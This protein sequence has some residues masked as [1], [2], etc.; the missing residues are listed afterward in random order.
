MNSH[1]KANKAS[2]K[3]L[4]ESR[5]LRPRGIKLPRKGRNFE[6]LAKLPAADQ[7]TLGGQLRSHAKRARPLAPR[8]TYH[9][10][11]RSQKARGAYSFL[12][13]NNKHRVFK[14]IKQQAKKFYVRIDQFANVGNHLHIKVYAQMPEE[15][16][17]FLRTITCLIARQVT[18][19]NRNKKFGQFWDALAFTRILKTF[20]EH[21]VLR[22][23]IFA[24]HI[25]GRHGPAARASYMIS[26][27]GLSRSKLGMASPYY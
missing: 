25:E 14:T 10:V 16:R 24:N 23:Y 11:L 17:H 2:L 5:K 7:A 6:L 21:Q 1:K 9:V 22:R 13:K 26:W 18:G 12:H 3:D 27:Y 20:T 15:F 4:R 19:A 8:S